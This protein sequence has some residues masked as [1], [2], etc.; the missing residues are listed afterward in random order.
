LCWTESLHAHFPKLKRNIT[1]YRNLRM[2]E[3]SE[4]S[5]ITIKLLFIYHWVI[6]Y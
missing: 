5:L 6:F 3:T 2:I 1:I 4:I